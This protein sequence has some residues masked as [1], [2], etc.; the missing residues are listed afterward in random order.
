MA[1]NICGNAGSNALTQIRA[2]FTNCALPANALT[3]TCIPAVANQPNNC[4]FG[5]NLG[6][7]C[8]YC[9]SS[10]PN[11]TDS[12]CVFS[13]STSRCNGVTL[14]VVASASLQAFTVTTTASATTTATVSPYGAVSNTSPGLTKGQIAGIAIG[15][16]L[17]AFF[18]LFLIIA[19]CLLLKRR[20]DNSPPTSIFNQPSPG[21][22]TPAMS[23]NTD[24]G[25]GGRS[26]GVSALSAAAGTGRVAR[27]A[28]LEGR[29]SA[30]SDEAYH[31][32]GYAKSLSDDDDEFDDALERSPSH[33]PALNVFAPLPQRTG[34]LSSA[35]QFGR[36]A[37]G[38]GHTTAHTDP[39]ARRSH[40][41]STAAGEYSSPGTTASSRVQSE[42]LDYFKDYY[43]TEDIHPGDLVATL[44][45]YEPRAA[46]E[47][48]LERGDMIKVLGIWDDGW[49]TG[50]R[51][52]G[53]R[54]EDWRAEGKVLRDSGITGPG[55]AEETT[56][57]S[58]SAASGSVGSPQSPGEGE[59]KAF[60]LVCVCLPQYWRK[61]IEGD[62]AA[63]AGGSGG[64]AAAE[65]VGGDAYRLE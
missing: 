55:G 53:Q 4:G 13:D 58:P 9:A 21:R 22:G 59:V 27:M 42:Q 26:G 37:L 32:G 11:A 6:G 39:A 50:L 60:P 48:P 56:L 18:L 57:S 62:A 31:F 23:Y 12:C 25:N 43:S 28:A 65:G 17:G 34:S 35:S 3:G 2:D 46:D 1:S 24:G 49:A 38:T 54:A 7:L 44:W 64:A 61:T 20:R 36:G 19:G 15:S 8:S 30:G 47:F 52:P 29:S 5:S 14:P 63:A 45:A 16:I 40:D 51:V 33:K 41:L 10:S